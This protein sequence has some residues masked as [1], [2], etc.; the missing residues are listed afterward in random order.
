MSCKVCNTLWYSPITKSLMWAVLGLGALDMHKFIERSKSTSAG[1]DWRDKR[2]FE[3]VEQFKYVQIQ[4]KDEIN[5]NGTFVTIKNWDMWSQR[6]IV[7]GANDAILNI[8]FCEFVENEYS[9]RSIGELSNN[10]GRANCFKCNCRTEK[11]RDFVDF[12]IREFCP[13][14]KI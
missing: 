9:I 11:R 6:F 8:P 13:R 4:V 2:F 1:M 10:K 5:M 14:C 7:R 12:S 3:H